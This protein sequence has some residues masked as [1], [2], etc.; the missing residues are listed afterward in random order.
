MAT[1]I[2]RKID[3]NAV[4]GAQIGNMRTQIGGLQGVLAEA[5]RTGNTELATQ[6]REQIDELNVSIAEAAAQQFQ[7]SIDEVNNQ[8]AKRGAA[9]D[10]RTRMA[11]IGG[12]TDF[13]AMGT[14]LKDRSNSILDQRFGLQNLLQQAQS[15]GNIDQVE[16]LTEQIAELDVQLAENTQAIQ[17]NTDAAFDFTTALI[18]STADFSQSVFSGA[19]GF[20]QALAEN[21][22]INTIPQQI[23]ALQGIATALRDQQ[24]GLIGQLA[25]LIGRPDLIGLTGADLVNALVAVASDPSVTAGMNPAQ[26]EAFRGLINA[27]LGNATAIEANTDA[28]HDLTDP[29]AQSF[30]SSLWSTFRSAVFTGAGGLLPQYQ[31]VV[32]SAATGAKV[33]ASGMLMVHSGETVRPASISRDY[34]STAGGDTYHLNVTTPTEVLNPTDVGRQLAFYRKNQ[35]RR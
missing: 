5:T 6:V 35:G 24:V 20:F 19:Q 11:Q 33:L 14:I 25:Q 15:L 34:G 12:R 1:A 31:A 7:N 17:D 8:A 28:I 21:T 3:P 30:S 2:G 9:L 18:N 27:L 13:N 10:R 23:A 32:P 22:G 16:S 29:G 26:L 4:L